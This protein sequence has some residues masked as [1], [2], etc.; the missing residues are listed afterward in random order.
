MSNMWEKF[1]ERMISRRNFIGMSLGSTTAL[2]LGGCSLTRVESISSALNTDEKG[3][4]VTAACWNNCGGRCLNKVYVE[5]GIAVRQKTDDTHADDPDYPQ[6]RACQRG[7]SRRKEVFGADR[8][9]YPM[10]RKNWEP[11]GGKKELRGRDEWVRISWDEALDII[12]S[13][14]KRIKENYGNKAILNVCKERSGFPWGR[15]LSKYG[16]YT[17]IWGTSSMGAFPWVCKTMQGGWSGVQDRMSLRKSK[18]IVLWGANPSWS[19]GGNPTRHYLQ[20]K[21]AGA[22]IICVDPFYNPSISTLADQFIPVRPSTDAVLLIGMAY[23][24]IT[25]NL[26]DQEFLDRYTVGFDSDHMPPGADPKE[27]F[28]DYVLGT[29]DG[30]PKT[31]EW[32]SAICGTD[33]AVIRSF[34]QECATIKPA[35]ILSSYS[36]ARTHGGEQFVQAFLTV[37]WMTG[38]V[39]R[40]GAMVGISTKETAADTDPAAPPLVKAGNN[41]VPLLINPLFDTSKYSYPLGPN[42]LESDWE[43]IVYDEVW[44]AVLNG[45]YTAGAR[46]QYPCDI[47][48]IC[49][50][51]EAASLNQFPNLKRGIEAYRKVEFVSTSAHFLTTPA[52]YSDIVLPAI[53]PWE[54]WGGVLSKDSGHGASREVL[55]FYRQVTEPLFE[56]KDEWWIESE[57]AKR[58]GIDPSIVAPLSPKQ[59]AFNQIAGATV[60]NPEGKDETLVTI[61]EEDIKRL[62]VQGK[63]QVGKVTYTEIEER[64]IYQI[65]REK[66]DDYKYIPYEKFIANPDANPLKTKTGKFQIYTQELSDTIAAFGW[67]KLPPIPQYHP[68]KHGFED[69]RNSEFPLQMI[70]LHYGRRAHTEYD[71]VSWLR[72]AYPQ[73]LFMNPDDALPRGIKDGDIIKVFNEYG[74]T[75]RPVTLTERIMPGVVAAGEGAWVEL[76]DAT[77][78]D[79]AGANNMLCGPH[80]CGQGVQPWNTGIVQ[81]QKYDKPLLPDYKWKQRIIL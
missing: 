77:G 45:K 76:D 64:G 67:S 54:K 68:V 71:N 65:K 16:G 2:M 81:V 8:L 9:K 70:S 29:Y 75:I 11:G 3:K 57:I 50:H 36:P 51:G 73:E 22:K 79:S 5:N 69:S 80:P 10:K 1:S 78:I 4:W 47:R 7:H 61:T 48:M 28:K 18:L 52:K 53:T 21:K 33:P 55:V 42:P 62:G 66:P 15:T 38:N 20:A 32:A 49:S 27:N 30:V 6:M 13:E 60:T 34:A 12:A 19:S 43:G 58:L 59:I 14:T 63:P 26:Q 46:G 23:H 17:T 24:M 41:G 74:A 40:P 39:G 72:E 25:N 37:G 44:E 56:A 35:A 31:P